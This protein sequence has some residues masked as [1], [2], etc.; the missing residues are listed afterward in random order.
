MSTNSLATAAVPA[1]K[2]KI[3]ARVLR[4]LA[5]AAFLAAGGAKLAGV[6]MMVGIYEQI[7]IGQWFRTVTGVVE[8][9]GAIGLLFP[10]TAGLGGL[11]L[12]VTMACAVMTHLFVIGGSAVP[13]LVLM[14]IT[15]A[16]AWLH[17]AG[18]AGV[19]NSLK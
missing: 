2:V 6:P 11:L 19:L 4:V 3:A 17:R 16:I 14:V 13:A 5:A 1:G 7:G 8:V 9:A 15:G 10:T 12:A 18:I